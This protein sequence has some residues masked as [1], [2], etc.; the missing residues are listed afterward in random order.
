[1][2]KEELFFGGG[3]DELDEAPGLGTILV[4]LPKE[5]NLTSP[6]TGFGSGFDGNAEG[7]GI[8]FPTSF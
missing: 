2:D 7:M 3:V 5:G 4:S 6:E 1:M 8:F